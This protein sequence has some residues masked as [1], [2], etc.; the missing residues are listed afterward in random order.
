[1]I[2]PVYVLSLPVPILCVE[3]L[4]SMKESPVNPAFESE[5]NNKEFPSSLRF[6]VVPDP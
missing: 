1:M 2:D 4:H 5:R 6:V 3:K